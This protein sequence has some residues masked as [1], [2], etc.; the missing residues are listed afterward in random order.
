MEKLPKK[1]KRIVLPQIR[2]Y[3]VQPNRVTKSRFGADV[4]GYT[5]SNHVLL[6]GAYSFGNERAPL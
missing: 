6:T 2:N 1:P 5:D 3:I 4:G